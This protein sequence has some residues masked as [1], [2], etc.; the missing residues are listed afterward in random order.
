MYIWCDV[1]SATTCGVLSYSF[2]ACC[3]NSQKN[4]AAATFSPPMRV[5]IIARTAECVP[6]RLWPLLVQSGQR[7]HFGLLERT[8]RTLA[9]RAV[10]RESSPA[11]D[12]FLSAAATYAA[13]AQAAA[14]RGRRRLSSQGPRFLSITL[15]CSLTFRAEHEHNQS[16][17]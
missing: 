5:L 3:F 11:A 14:S 2:Q 9:S 13:G 6:P 17:S 16:L 15:T 8:H 7:L 4:T 12:T 1:A 10:Q